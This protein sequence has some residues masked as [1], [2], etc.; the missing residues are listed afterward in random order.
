MR[1]KSRKI[2]IQTELKIDHKFY[3]IHFDVD[4]SISLC[5]PMY[6]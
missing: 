3:V 4:S 6:L 5:I 1:F 2:L